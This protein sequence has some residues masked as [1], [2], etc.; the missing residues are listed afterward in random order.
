MRLFIR[1]NKGSLRE[2]SI[3]QD[4]SEIVIRFGQIG[5]SIQEKRELVPFGKA[6]RTQQEQIDLQI[7]SRISKQKDRG[8]TDT[9]E[10]A[11]QGAKNQLGFDR[12]MLAQRFDRVNPNLDNVMLQ[13]KLDGNRCCITK[14]N[15]RII[16]YSRNGKIIPADL[17]HITDGLSLN[18]GQTIDGELYCHGEKLQT[19]V[20]W[21]KR[22]QDDTAR[23]RFHAYDIFDDRPYDKRMYDII[24][25]IGDNKSAEFIPTIRAS[26]A[27]EIYG[28]HKRSLNLGYEGTIIRMPDYGYESGKRSRSLLKLKTFLDAEFEVSDIIESKDG[29]A[30]LECIIPEGGTFRVSAPGTMDEKVEILDFAEEY[31]GQFVNVEYAQLT[32]DGKPFHPVATGFRNIFDE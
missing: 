4:G 30:I 15:G 16:P 6:G 25:I 14:R 12:P 24:D 2:W 32:K 21:I 18:E 28:Y 11:Q 27:D 17:S 7:K 19:I 5:G 29:W 23:L 8:Y 22:T 9:I 31:I 20:S 3:T 13:R 1:D 26:G 10:K